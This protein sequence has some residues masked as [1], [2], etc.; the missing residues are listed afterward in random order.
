MFTP[1][2]SSPLLTNMEADEIADMSPPGF[3]FPAKAQ[4][5]MGGAGVQQ[6]LRFQF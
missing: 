4:L 2:L 5:E 1:S 3:G 6:G